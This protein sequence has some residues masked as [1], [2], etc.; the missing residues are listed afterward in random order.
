MKRLLA[1]IFTFLFVAAAGADEPPGI[2]NPAIDMNAHIRLTK[3]AAK[4]RE[5]R[6][7]TEEEFLRMSR[8][9]GTIVLDARSRA[10]YDLLHVKGAVHLSYPDFTADALAEV[11]PSKTT[12]I[13]IYCNNNFLNSRAFMTKAPPASLNLVTYPTLYMYGYENVYE[14]GP[15]VAIEN[16]K[17]EFEGTTATTR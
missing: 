9:P 2:S 12:R 8:E 13:L 14:L 11:I 6:R 4:L 16:S 5:N 17:L 1:G 7:L 15:L 10:M 3:E